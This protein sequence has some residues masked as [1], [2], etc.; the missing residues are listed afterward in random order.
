[1]SYKS[2][3]NTGIALYGHDE[4]DGWKGI[5]TYAGGRT[6]GTEKWRRD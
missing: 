1:M 4:K 5:W 2:G 6:V 3:R